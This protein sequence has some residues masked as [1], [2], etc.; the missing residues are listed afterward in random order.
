MTK[1]S[2]K[3]SGI[4]ADKWPKIA[5]LQ[6]KMEKISKKNSGVTTE[7]WPKIAEL[8]RKIAKNSVVATGKIKHLTEFLLRKKIYRA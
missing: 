2:K 7:K 3:N 8:W 6:W 5:E 1:V 4:V